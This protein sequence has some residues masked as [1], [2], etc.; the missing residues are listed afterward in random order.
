MF[1][2]ACLGIVGISASVFL[3]GVFGHIY[4]PAAEGLASPSD[5]APGFL[6]DPLPVLL[7]IWDDK[8]WLARPYVQ[9]LHILADVQQ[10]STHPL[11]LA[12]A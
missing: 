10:G 12:L 4:V 2:S 7:T 8:L 9:P 11:W 1:K 6:S 3:E 5:T